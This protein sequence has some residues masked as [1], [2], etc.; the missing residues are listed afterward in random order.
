MLF[1]VSCRSTNEQSIEQ[2]QQWSTMEITLTAEGTYENSYTD[3]EVRAVFKDAKNNQMVRPAFWDGGKIWKVRFAPPDSNNIWEWQTYASNEEDLGL[4]GISGKIQSAPYSGSNTLIS[5]GLLKM[6]PGKRNVIHHDGYPFPV[7]GDTP[8]AMPFRA[9]KDQVKKYVNRSFL[10]AFLECRRRQ[11]LS[12]ILNIQ[13]L[14]EAL[15]LKAAID[16]Q[17]FASTS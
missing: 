11:T 13:V 7:V 12:V 8:W 16:C 5:H 17:I 2:V 1:L 6:S 4:H 15:Y 3:V 9:T 14:S 10:F